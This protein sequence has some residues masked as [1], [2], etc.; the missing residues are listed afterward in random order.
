MIEMTFD[1]YMA[2]LRKDVEYFETF[3]R[4]NHEAA[5]DEFPMEMLSGDWDEQFV[6]SKSGR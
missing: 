5:P 1:E 3:W 4:E 2:E 6:L